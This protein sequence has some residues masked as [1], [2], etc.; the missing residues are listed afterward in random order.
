MVVKKYPRIECMC[1]EYYTDTRDLPDSYIK[2][3]KSQK[4]KRNMSVV[5]LYS[6]AALLNGTGSVGDPIPDKYIMRS[7]QSELTLEQRQ[8]NLEKKRAHAAA[9]KVNAALLA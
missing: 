3:R 7:P 1:G 4:H 8:A 2:H 5:M 6:Q 9:V